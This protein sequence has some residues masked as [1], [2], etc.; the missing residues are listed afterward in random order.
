MAFYCYSVGDGLFGL[1]NIAVTSVRRPR[2]QF[3]SHTFQ[4]NKESEKILSFFSVPFGSYILRN[5]T[6]K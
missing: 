5:S 4:S 6:I 2:K 3:Y 1:C